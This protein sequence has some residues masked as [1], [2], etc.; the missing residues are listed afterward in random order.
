MNTFTS[1]PSKSKSMIKTCIW[2]RIVLKHSV[3]V[4]PVLVCFLLLLETPEINQLLKRK[5]FLWLT[6]LKVKVCDWLAPLLWAS[7]GTVHHGGSIWQ[8][9]RPSHF[10]GRWSLG[11]QTPFWRHAPTDLKFP[12]RSHLSKAPPPNRAMS[13]APT[14]AHG[15]LGRR[16]R[17]KP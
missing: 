14:L 12:C 7:G 9:R 15:P 5:S 17:L 16:L 6:V 13:R 11:S 3:T 1:L 10:T 4:Y 8:R 2:F